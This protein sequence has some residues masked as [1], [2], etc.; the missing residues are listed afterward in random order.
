MIVSLSEM[1]EFLSIPSGITDHDTFLTNQLT[2]V[3]EIV[4]NYCRRKFEAANYTQKFY[5]RQ[6]YGLG[7]SQLM[8]AMYPIISVT[9]VTKDSSLVDSA[10]YHFHKP[11]GTLFWNSGLV[12]SDFTEIVYRAG[13]ESADMP[14]TLKNVIYSI[15][16]ER[17][18][19]KNTGVALNFGS[20]VQRISIPGAISID[21]D[22][23]L[24]NNDRSTPFG[25]VLGSQ[26]NILDFY[27]SERAIQPGT[28]E[29]V[30]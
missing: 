2:Y 16:E 25:S 4:E 14:A 10:D 29:F 21:F 6:Y 30:T 23:S 12:G 22:Y 13:F 3:Q 17:Y 7:T 11:S 15:V 20:D 19:K 26:T 18:N 28:I 9:S 27:R 1:K 5:P 8:L 24:S